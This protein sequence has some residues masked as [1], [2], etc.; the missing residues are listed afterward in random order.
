[1][2]ERSAGILLYRRSGAETSFFLVHPGGPYFRGKDDG[3]WSIPKGLVGEG[4]EPL[5]AA[6]R[7]LR[8]ETGIEVGGPFMALGEVRQK[9]GKLVAAWAAEYREEGCPRVSS[10]TFEIEWP[11]RSGRRQSHPEVDRG[12]FFGRQAAERKIN[13]AQRPFLERLSAAL[14]GGS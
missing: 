12:E 9:G 6:R 1:M 3:H 2:A 11:P 13:E 5:A 10:N 8:E 14:P 7:E 4:E